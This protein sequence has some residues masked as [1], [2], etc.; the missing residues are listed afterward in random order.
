[1]AKREYTTTTTTP[2]DVTKIISA[3]SG[4][5]GLCRCGCAGKYYYQQATRE[6]A[7]KERG[8]EVHDN[9]ISPVMINKIAKF[10]NEHLSD[11]EVQDGYIFDI[12]VSPS[13]SYTVYYQV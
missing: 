10:M 1:M 4:K 11:V 2:I 12:E 7:S 9:E 5:T 3:Y 13:R 6:I 8:H